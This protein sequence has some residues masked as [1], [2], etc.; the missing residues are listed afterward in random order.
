MCANLSKNQ[1]EKHSQKRHDYVKQSATDP[2]KTSSK[3]VLQ[4]EAEATSDLNGNKI[5]V[6]FNG[7][8][9][10][11]NSPKIQDETHVKNF[12]QYTST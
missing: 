3:R 7:V 8:Y 5:A 1:S 6:K 9:S 2:P 10:R 12:D 4:K 11:N